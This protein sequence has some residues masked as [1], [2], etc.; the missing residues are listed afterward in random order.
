MEII[1]F[2]TESEI[3]NVHNVPIETTQRLS[4]VHNSA[5]S[6]PKFGGYAPKK[7]PHQ[8]KGVKATPK[9]TT[10]K[11]NF[12]YLRLLYIAFVIFNMF[13]EIFLF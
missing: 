5:L 3:Y 7:L 12:N 9:P 6:R 10:G 1:D 8:T 4:D 2:Y 13:L 11:S